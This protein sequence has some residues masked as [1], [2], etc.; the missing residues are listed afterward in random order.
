[1]YH[2]TIISLLVIILSCYSII[3]YN[4]QLLYDYNNVKDSLL[5]TNEKLQTTLSFIEYK[6]FPLEDLF[7][8]D[9]N[10]EY[11]DNKNNKLLI[12]NSNDICNTLTPSIYKDEQQQ[13][14]IPLLSLSTNSLV[15]NSIINLLKSKEDTSYNKDYNPH[16]HQYHSNSASQDIILTYFQECIHLLKQKNRIHGYYLFD[17]YDILLIKEQSRDLIE[18]IYFTDNRISVIQDILVLIHLTILFIIFV[19]IIYYSLTISFYYNYIYEINP[20]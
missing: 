2:L 14:Q 6:C 10:E 20:I 4:N 15:Y 12:D 1:M 11:K 13:Q 16:H 19:T 5:S 8:V 9:D 3:S 17:S 18:L 7:L